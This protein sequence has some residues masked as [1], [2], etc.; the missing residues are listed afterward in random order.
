[1][2]DILNVKFTANADFG[3]LISEANRAMAVLSKFRN[4][5]L[6]DNIGLNKKDFD[7]AVGE[8]RKA[9]TAAGYYNSSIVD[10]TSSTQKFGKELAGQ[11]LKLKDYYSAWSEYSRGAQGQIR[12]LAQEQVRMNSSVVKSLGRDVT[13]AQKAMVLTPTGIDA[14]ANASKIAASELSIYHKVL[15]DGSTSLINWG[16]NT[17]WAG[18]QLTVGLTLPLAIFG[19]AASQAFREADMELTRLAK[20]YGGIGGVSS[21]QLTKVKKDV[22]E[23]AQTLSSTYGASF[24]ETLGLSADIAATGK[25]GNDLLGSIAETTRLATLG[26]VDRQ[27]AMKATLALQSAFSMNTKELAES[28]N[29]LNAVENQ[30]ST[31][32]QDFTEAIPKAGPVVQGLGGDIKDLAV[33]MTAMKEGGINAAEGANALKSGLASMI[34]PTKVSR[35]LLTGWGVSIEDI[36]TGNSGDIVGM[37]LDLKK[38]LDQLDP[39]QK[40]KAIEQ[41]F[42]KY[43]FARI[44]ALLENLGKEGSQTLQVFD[45][46]KASTTD[47]GS[48][49]D[50]ELKALTESASGRYKR[51]LETFKAA[52]A[53]IGEPFL[54]I[55]AKVLDVGGRV[56][57][58]FGKMPAPLKAFVT[59]MGVL[60]ALAG[61]LIMLTGLM[62]NFFGYIIK[63]VNALRQF[64]SGAESFKLVTTE[65]IAADH[66]ADSYTQ[67]LYNQKDAAMVLRTELER[68]ALAYRDVASGSM[69]GAPPAGV[70]VATAPVQGTSVA[71][72]SSRETASPSAVSDVQAFR[73]IKSGSVR[74]VIQSEADSID[75]Q[76]AKL[77]EAERRSFLEQELK[78]QEA[79]RQASNSGGGRKVGGSTAGTATAASAGIYGITADVLGQGVE[80]SD[81]LTRGNMRGGPE[82]LNLAT[83]QSGHI[84]PEG[85]SKTGAKGS[86]VMDASLNKELLNMAEQQKLLTDEALRT[87]VIANATEERL[88]IA[89]G[90]GGLPTVSGIGEAFG[91]IR[92]RVKNQEIMVPDSIKGTSV[93]PSNAELLAI[94]DD[95]SA[96]TLSPAASQPM[97]D[98]AKPKPTAIDRGR[99][100]KAAQAA[101]DQKRLAKQSG[102]AAMVADSKKTAVA[103]RQS[104]QAAGM[105]ANKIGMAAGSIGLASS[106]MLALSGNTN[107]AAMKAAN[108]A[109]ALG[110]ALPAIGQLR[111]GVLG[112]STKLIDAG[113]KAAKL[114]SVLKFAGG[115]WGMALIAGITAAVF[116]IKFFQKKHAEAL[117]KA[118]ADIDVS[119]DALE[120]FGG[121]ALS[122][123]NAFKAYVD[124][125]NALKNKLISDSQSKNLLGLPTQEEIDGVKEQVAKLFKDQIMAAGGLKDKDTAVQFATN[126]KATLL[127]QGVAEA[128]ANTIIASIMQQANKQEFTVPVLMEIKG[129]KTKEEAFSALKKAAE[130]TFQDINLKIKDGVAIDEATSGRFIAQINTLSAA[131]L[132]SVREFEDIGKSIDVLP[133]GMKNLSFEQLNA[134][135]SGRALLAQMQKINEPLYLALKSSDSLA[136]AIKMAAANALGLVSALEGVAGRFDIAG[137]QAA[138]MVAN[139]AYAAS[140]IQKSFNAQIA[141]QNSIIAKIK[142]RAEAAKNARD[143]QKKHEEDA[144]EGLKNEID[145]LKDQADAR[146]DLLRTAQDT[147]NFERDIQA[148]R[149]EQQQALMTGNFAEAAII[150]LQIDKKMQDRSIDLAENAIDAKL[151][152]ETKKRED[153]IKM[154]EERLKAIKALTDAEVK[155][156]EEKAAKEIAAHQK[157]IASIQQKAGTTAAEFKRLFTEVAQGNVSKMAELNS[158]IKGVGGN[159]DAISKAVA[160]SL[161]TAADS[162]RKFFKDIVKGMLGDKFVVGE[163]GTIF[164]KKAGVKGTT[165][166]VKTGSSLS[167]VFFNTLG[168]NTKDGIT[169]AF[170]GSKVM[171]PGYGEATVKEDSKGKYLEYMA[172]TIGPIR[173]SADP[174]RA[175]Q[176]VV[177]K[178][179]ADFEANR[180][181]FRAA[182]GPVKKNYMIK[183][184]RFDGGFTQKSAFPYIVGEKGPELMIPNMNGN[185][186]PS[187]RLF[188][189]VRQMNNSG[190]ESGNEYNINVSVINPGASADQIASAI[191]SKMKLMNQRVGTNNTVR[192]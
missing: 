25:E 129:I 179:G 18:R 100:K 109:T 70:P 88:S 103:T 62:A 90:K 123:S 111:K 157:I 85:K 133:E 158:L 5:S 132:G 190:G 92:K 6:A 170:V 7:T 64:R 105:L 8:F 82:I 23:L 138:A 149:L 153:E 28:I 48:I 172:D 112:V 191:E 84:N 58:V 75:A 164:E 37:M 24:K 78:K 2:A 180:I 173:T 30:T 87:Q 49:A 163:D 38:A 86:V 125:A 128:Q 34:N 107:Q 54:N 156:I 113:G 116:A 175:A 114:G 36:V 29:F 83:S 154:H 134:T 22:T 72:F 99:R 91:R 21:E 41:L 119:A 67:S 168:K 44:N 51:A 104:A 12:K 136:G 97:V 13:G 140:G 101:R 33:L 74:G 117:A 135:T 155:A 26:D 130:K 56:L 96:R 139:E 61:P 121:R 31:T 152:A 73:D 45:L 57:G 182:G 16:K 165:K 93:T 145:V 76:L 3:Q 65:T 184:Q 4:Q 60:T 141:G 43:Q 47:L 50:R 178:Y 120:A 124:N 150:G 71:P 42:G 166:L 171:V 80:G 14:V 181:F 187:D 32:L 79:G 185:V 19:K 183:G 160:G 95:P 151:A 169:G 146:K 118:K 53:D 77:P 106:M 20:V 102:G 122:A 94:R 131:A 147:A 176:E 127:A 15:R 162:F 89:R 10:V 98:T 66:V 35:D 188:N 137:Q 159:T 115:P 81:I 59:G 1:M 52:I 27:E 126:L 69:G 167:D 143:A 110:F 55:M 108:L 148:S 177:N 17:Q 142:Q 40:Q 39:L 9:V 11:R 161:E 68:L 46:M 189:A 186:V 174:V 192:V 63:G 144:I